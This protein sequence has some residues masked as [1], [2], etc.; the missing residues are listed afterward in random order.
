M[1]EIYQ[2][3]FKSNSFNVDDLMVLFNWGWPRLINKFSLIRNL[4][5]FASEYQNDQILLNSYIQVDDQILLISSLIRYTHVFWSSG[6]KMAPYFT[7]I[8]NLAVITRVTVNS[9]RVD[10]HLKVKFITEQ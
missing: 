8:S 7:V 5:L 4:N 3:M 6:K 10:L 2:Q 9:V 1:M